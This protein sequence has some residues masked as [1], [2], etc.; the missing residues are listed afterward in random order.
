VTMMNGQTV[1]SKVAPVND[2]TM[3]FTFVNHQ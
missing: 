1:L 3:A 2:T